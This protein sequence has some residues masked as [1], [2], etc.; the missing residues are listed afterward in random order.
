[1]LAASKPPAGGCAGGWGWNSM[2][3]SPPHTPP[4]PDGAVC[5]DWAAPGRRRPWEGTTEEC[6]L[7]QAVF[8][9]PSEV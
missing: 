4:T 3:V 8:G 9:A 7:E 2:I 1:M 6:G 5:P